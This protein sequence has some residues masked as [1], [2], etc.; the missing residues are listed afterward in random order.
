MIDAFREYNCVED[1]IELKR[2]GD[3]LIL[4]FNGRLLF[5]APKAAPTSFSLRLFFRRPV[6]GAELGLVRARSR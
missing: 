1:H 6:L 3:F 4:D 2:F 5:Y